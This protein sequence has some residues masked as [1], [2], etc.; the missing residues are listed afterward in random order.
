MILKISSVSALNSGEEI[1]ITFECI[2]DDGSK[3]SCESFVIPSGK[4]LTMGLAKGECTTELYDDV[5]CL[6][7]VWQATKCG[8]RILANGA[9][10]QKALRIK[11][12][13]KGFDKSVATEAVLQ[14]EAMGLIREKENAVCV[15][16]GFAMKLWGKR[17]IASGLYEK[18]YSSTAIEYALNTLEDNGTDYTESCKRLVEKS[19]SHIPKEQRE[20]GK[21]IASLQRYG[22]SMSEIK[23]AFTLVNKK[24]D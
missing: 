15:A 3:S 4:Y 2:S 24:A 22:Y 13:S 7:E 19:Y 14:L 12:I 8:M 21:L 17:R 9:C 11:L 18:G 5:A 16:Q 6:S 1:R 10:S 20:R 23:Q